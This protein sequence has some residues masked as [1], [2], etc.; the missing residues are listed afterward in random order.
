[1]SRTLLYALI[2]LGAVS[3]A[4]PLIFISTWFA[5]MVWL[6]FIFLLDPINYLRL[7]PSMVGDL[8]RGSYRRLFSLLTAGG[9]CGI[10]W[11]FWN[12]WAIS[13]WTYT[14]PFLGNVRI[15]EMPVLG[16]LG[17]TTFAV[18]CWVM[19]IFLRSLLTQKPTQTNNI[20]IE[21]NHVSK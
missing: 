20:W 9:I 21:S 18:E 6:S 8:E 15:F 16:Y 2:I 1:M 3:A 13:R 17:F 7:S 5:P 4:V 10:L 12:Y 11:E 19:Y 14:V